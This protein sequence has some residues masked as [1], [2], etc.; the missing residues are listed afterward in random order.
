[1]AIHDLWSFDNA[2]VGTS[3]LTGTTDLT[4][5]TGPSNVYNYY[6]GNPGCTYTYASSPLA[7]DANGFA[8][9]TNNSSGNGSMIWFKLAQAL[10]MSGATKWGIGF[11]TKSTQAVTGSTPGRVFITTAGWA[12]ATLLIWINEADLVAPAN[13]ELYVELIVDSATFTYWLYVNGNLVR[14]A[15][16]G[17]SAFPATGYGVFGTGGTAGT[18]NAA[19]GYRDFYFLDFDSTD[20]VRLGPIRSSPAALS[21]I[22]GAG[23]TLNSAADLP[24][25]ITTA[26][27]NPPVTT[28][29]ASAPANNQPVTANMSTGVSANT[30]I[31]AVQPQ[32]T[33]IGD[34][35]S[36]SI[37]V[38]FSQASNT[39]D[40]GKI[41]VS[42]NTNLYNQKWGVQRKAPDGGLWTPAKINAASAILTPKTLNTVLLMHMESF[43]DDTGR[44]WT[45]NGNGVL[46][47][48]QVAMG[49]KSYN[50]GTTGN[51]SVASDSTMVLGNAMTVEFWLY[52]TAA[53][54]D[55]TILSS[56]TANT[57]TTQTSI[58]QQ[59]D[60]GLG[61]Y[62]TDGS[63]WKSL[64]SA[65][66]FTLNKWQHCAVVYANGV[67]TGYIG[68]VAQGTLTSALTFGLSGSTWTIGGNQY[69][70]ASQFPGYIDELR[71]SNIARYTANFTPPAAPFVLD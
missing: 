64:A 52:R 56:K 29:S 2:P 40:A 23:W 60:K 49:S 20:T 47:T 53:L 19:R 28:P 42:P 22:A 57:T 38:S 68:G 34:S 1:M 44:T 66:A 46:T 63:G 15:A 18:A 36:N 11:R 27:Q 7:V 21:N 12:T 16:Y 45:S 6:T 30:P 13:T 41:V 70:T 24:T 3:L 71:V 48:G 14:S 10:N 39:L 8:T 55:T 65:A 62:L 32:L 25:A 5:T 17:A 61:I 67:Y 43:V 4:S 35:A 33:L 69:N 58:G 51:L 50:S 26:L 9:S 54:G 37:D 31:I 59:S